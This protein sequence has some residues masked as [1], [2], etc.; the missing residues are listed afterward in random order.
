MNN[1]QSIAFFDFDGTISNKDSLLEFLKFAVGNYKFYILTFFFI[2]SLLMFKLNIITNEK[3]KERMIAFFLKR[4]KE[5]DFKKDASN[6]SLEHL[7]KILRPKAIEKLR[8]HK[9]KNH[10]IVIVSASIEDWLRPWCEKN[11]YDILATRLEFK[12]R[13]LTG[14]FLT[15][16]CYG[17][18]KVNRIKER[19]NL[20]D[21]EN[22]YV[23]GDSRGDKEMLSIGNK[24]FFKPFIN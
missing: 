15:R 5:V 20:E 2:P 21:Y 3:A 22:V 4:K 8:W 19:Y 9:K 18:E 24:S 17:Q 6:Y 7:H 16:N 12:N 1:N 14:K 13:Y 11:G 23:Y 10:K